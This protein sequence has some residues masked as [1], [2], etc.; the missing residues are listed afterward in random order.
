MKNGKR[1][2][3]AGRVFP[4]KEKVFSEE[5]LATDSAGS[6]YAVGGCA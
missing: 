4:Q 3:E 6:E 1:K 5:W 2:S